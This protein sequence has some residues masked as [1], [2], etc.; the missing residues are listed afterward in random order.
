MNKGMLVE[1]TKRDFTE[2]YSGSILG[3][4]WSFIWPLV[5]I[6]IYVVIFSKIM[7]AK[8]P[9]IDSVY[10][11]SIYL[12]AGILPWTT[13]S[14]TV[15]RSATVFM[16]KKHI[17]SKVRISLVRLPMFIV[18]SE[19]IT[20]FFSMMIFFVI[21]M[22]A[23]EGFLDK[24][25]LI[26]PLIYVIQQIF[27]F[28]IGF[29]FAVFTVFIKDL[30]EVLQI[31]LQ[32]WF[33]FT[34]IVYVPNILPDYAMKFMEYNPAYLFIQAYHSILAF[35]TAPDFNKLITLTIL[36]HVMFFIAFVFY[37][38]LEKDIRDFL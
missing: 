7:S 32:L 25:L 22:F 24:R 23:M 26:L 33:W 14:N 3:A 38:I 37:R 6:F 28:S 30:K 34:P 9:G 31:I 16:D 2:R 36:A 4:L 17:I 35:G 15:S 27:A 20:F 29:F 13:F 10:S 8:L 12:V 19:S 18:F 5:L 1:L 11:Y 21:L